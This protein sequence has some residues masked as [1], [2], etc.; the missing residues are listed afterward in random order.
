MRRTPRLLA[1]VG[2]GVALATVGA[3]AGSAFAGAPAPSASTPAPSPSAPGPGR[4]APDVPLPKHPTLQQVQATAAANISARLTRLNTAIGKVQAETDLGADQATLVRI[5]SSDVSGLQQL[6]TT[7]AGA[8][9]VRSAVTDYRQMF[10]GYR[11]Y[12]LALPVVGLVSTDDHLTAVAVP[13]LEAAA[14]RIA[15]HEKPSD[16]AQVQALLSEMAGQLTAATGAVAGDP[17]TLEGDTPAEWNAD[18][19]L[20]GTARAAT[21]TAAMDVKAARADAWQAEAALRSATSP[22]RVRSATPPTPPG[23][24]AT[25]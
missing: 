14:T 12:A 15:S 21:K 1:V 5:L 10:T 3:T 8:T 7:V 9:T 4:P 19:G 23:A 16:Q 22:G 24:T 17:A 13:R 20:L 11:V 2:A 25:G 6:E 18:H